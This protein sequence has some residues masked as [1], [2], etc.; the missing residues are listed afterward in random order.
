MQ[1]NG[2]SGDSSHSALP[3][4]LPLSSERLDPEAILLLE[5]GDDAIIFVNKGAHSDILFDL[6]G[7][8]SVDEIAP[9]PVSEGG[10]RSW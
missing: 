9:G 5:N 7:L 10:R 6:F 3:P 4:T 1:E 2:D 8:R